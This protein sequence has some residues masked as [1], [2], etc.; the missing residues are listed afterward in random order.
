MFCA[1]TPFQLSLYQYFLTSPEG[2]ATLRGKGAQPLKAINLLRQIV[3]HPALVNLPE[4]LPGSESLWPED[5]DHKSLSSRG[6]FNPAYGGKML[7][8]YRFVLLFLAF[9]LY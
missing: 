4:A 9:S 5:Y 6:V 2:K 8:L 3:N 1:L 7:V